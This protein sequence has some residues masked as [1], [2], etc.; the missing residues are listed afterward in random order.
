MIDFIKQKQLAAIQIVCMKLVQP[1]LFCGYVLL[2]SFYFNFV[3]YKRKH[4]HYLK[5]ECLSI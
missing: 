3:S 1:V 5:I 4:M 2:S